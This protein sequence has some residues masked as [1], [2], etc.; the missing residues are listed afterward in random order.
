MIMW[1]NPCAEVQACLPLL[2]GGELLGLDR[3]RTERHLLVCARCRHRLSA[4]R[5]ALGVLD[6]VADQPLL[7]ANSLPLWPALAQQIQES[8]RPVV[9]RGR[10]RARLAGWSA[11]AAVMAILVTTWLL[12]PITSVNKARVASAPSRTSTIPARSSAPAVTAPVAARR[13][14]ASKENPSVAE[15]PAPTRSGADSDHSATPSAD[16]RYTQ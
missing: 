10:L 7:P 15:T 9:A 4:L 12:S 8:R 11:A 6:A 2:A 13:D 3:R 16:S 14:S 1:R 5:A